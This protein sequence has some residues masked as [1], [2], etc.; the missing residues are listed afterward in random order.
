MNL[1]TI[2]RFK[3]ELIILLSLILMLWAL[4]YKHQAKTDLQ[5]E[6]E[7]I[8]KSIVEISRVSELKK[9]WGDKK[10]GKKLDQFKS[11]VKREK[12]KSIEKRAKRLTASYQNLDVR[13]LNKITKILLK[14]PV[15]ITKLSIEESG[16]ERYTME[17]K[18]KW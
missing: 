15:Q 7:S 6:K 8:S 1:M 9:L 17:F 3:N 13:E 10:I 4:L 16:K 14:T 11:I 2:K 12:I 5:T 18:C